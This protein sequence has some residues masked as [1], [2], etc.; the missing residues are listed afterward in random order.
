MRVHRRRTPGLLAPRE[1]SPLL[2]CLPLMSRCH[3]RSPSGRHRVPVRDFLAPVVL[4]ARRAGDLARGEGG[5]PTLL[6]VGTERRTHQLPGTAVESPALHRDHYRAPS[7]LTFLTN[8]TKRFK[9]KPCL[10]KQERG[11]FPLQ[12]VRTIASIPGTAQPLPSCRVVLVAMGTVSGC[13]LR[14]FPLA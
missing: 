13:E 2:S 7:D 3:L 4:R 14:A 6:L 5:L 12:W 8:P 11:A 9:R 1:V 10:R